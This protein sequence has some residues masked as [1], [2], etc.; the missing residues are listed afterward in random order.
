MLAQL[1][2]RRLGKA[3]VGSS[4]LLGSLKEKRLPQNAVA[5]F[6]DIATHLKMKQSF[7]SG[8]GNPLLFY[9]FLLINLFQIY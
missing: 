7:L 3:E 5:S 4:N 1:V 8:T 2:E 6:S 9:Q